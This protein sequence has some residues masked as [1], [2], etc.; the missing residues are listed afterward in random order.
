MPRFNA[1]SRNAN[2][3]D[4][5]FFPTHEEIYRLQ[6]IKQAFRREMKLKEFK[7]I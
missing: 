7:E 3:I 5:N 1:F 2:K 4:L 6:K